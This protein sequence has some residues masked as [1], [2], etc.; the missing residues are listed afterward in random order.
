MTNDEW[1]DFITSFTKSVQWKS[2]GKFLS[3]ILFFLS[4]L[5]SRSSTFIIISA[6]ET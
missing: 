3:L 6:S 2:G 5:S 4:F 1:K